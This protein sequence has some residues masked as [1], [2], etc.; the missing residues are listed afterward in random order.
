MS[1]NYEYRYYFLE[2]NIDL[3]IFKT[4]FTASPSWCWFTITSLPGAVHTFTHHGDIKYTG[5]YSY[6][7]CH[8]HDLTTQL[9]TLWW[10][11][12][13]TQVQ[14]TQSYDH[15]A[16]MPFHHYISPLKIRHIITRHKPTLHHNENKYW[17]ITDVTTTYQDA[18]HH[19]VTR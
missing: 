10:Y 13:K 18:N 1:R 3:E 6:S 8:H 15:E 11:N 9:S 16:V 2:I 4:E 17:V 5:I 19:C 7:H 12:T 14:N